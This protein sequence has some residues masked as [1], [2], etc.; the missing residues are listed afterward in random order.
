MPSQNH[1]ENPRIFNIH[2]EPPRAS[3]C[4]YPDLGTCRAGGESPLYKSLDGDWKF[5]W[6]PRPADRPE[7]FYRLDWDISTWDEIPV[8]GQWQLF[9]YG[10]PHYMADG[11]VKGMGKKNLPNID[12]DYNEIGSYRRTFTLPA[13]WGGKQMYIHFAGVKTAFYLWI[14]AERVGYSQGSMCPAEFNI[15]PFLQPGEN[16]LAVEV[17]RYS[18]GAYLE[19]QDMWYMAGVYREVVLMALPEVHIHDFYAR[20]RWDDSCQNAVFYLDVKVR[21][22][23]PHAA[24]GYQVITRLLDVD[25]NLVLNEVAETGP[26]ESGGDT[27]VHFEAQVSDPRKWSAEIPNL[28]T[29]EIGLLEPDGTPMA[30]TRVPFGFR[31]VEIQGKEILINGQNIVFRGV[32][33]HECHP[34]VGQSISKEHMER[35]VILMKQY[36]INAVRTSHYPNHPYFYALCDRYGLYVMDEANVETHGTAR[37]IPGDNPDWTAAVVDRMVR[38]V[39]RD[40]NHPSVV[41]WSL[42]NEAGYG[43]NFERMKQAALAIDSTR[44]IHYEG[45]ITLKTTEVVST[46]YPSPMRMEKMAKGEEKLRLSSAGNMGGKVHPPEAYN[47]MPIL[48][49]EYT[50]AM[51]NS[52]GSLDRHVQLFDDYPHMAG[53]FIWDFVDQTLLK[54]DPEGRDLWLYGGDFGDQPSGKSFLANGIL[55]ADRSPH[56]HAFQ[57][58]HSYRPVAT[59]PVDLSAGVVRIRNK[60]WFQTT[61]NY[62]ILWVLTVDGERVQEGELEELAIAPQAEA[63][64]KLPLRDLAAAGGGE[65]HL[66]LTYVLRQATSW[67]PAGFEIAWDQF[68]VPVQR[69]GNEQILVGTDI[70]MT[71]VSLEMDADWVLVVGEGFEVAFERHSGLWRRLS[72]DG[73][74]IFRQPLNPNFWRTPIDNDG[75]ALLENTSIP[76]F[77]FPILL[78]WQR[79]KTAAQKRKLVYFGVKQVGEDRVVLST[80]FKIPRGK[81][82]LEIQYT[83]RGDGCVEVAYSFT[84][85]VKL[86]RAGL[87][88][89]I[90]GAYRTITWYGRGPQES[91]LDR[92]S[93]YAV[94]IYS[95][96]IEDFIH[97]YVRPQENAN[98]TDVRWARFQDGSGRGLEILGVG[99]SRFHFSA[100]PY[101]MADLESAEHIHELP[102][103]EDLT[104]NID[105]GQQGAGDLT[106][107]LMGL[108]EEAQ[109][110]G[111]SRCEYRFIIKGI[112]PGRD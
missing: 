52:V 64:V 48:V 67:A 90:P 39:E 14:N 66:K 13:D 10:T 45:D 11:G 9:G 84:P 102:R 77:L 99:E 74:E 55:A 69:K 88:T 37:Q 1:W 21:N 35:D 36:N 104:V 82:P 40:K 15:T 60:N 111:G 105:Y 33:R 34:E 86:M 58:K 25:E 8:P 28:Y 112:K 43:S 85:R 81:T 73:K 96:D 63:E 56:P 91:M 4:Y 59:V 3:A 72:L 92:K 2:K 80:R 16:N 95:Q 79:W 41:S 26:F 53:G 108:P 42:G 78:P 103:R 75:S 94:G 30:A 68:E 71:P 17:Y 22:A 23:G 106:S 76:S 70:E 24:G 89:A 54:K 6:S 109:L 98:R 97:N 46:M 31:K 62:R 29:L 5:H 44:F 38:M 12:R 7:E 32:N 65:M 57:V 107:A 61:Q 20:S 100:W 51:G 101:S 110:L 18:D 83:V 49:C 27:A 47:T 93:G 87:Q 50:H 19:D